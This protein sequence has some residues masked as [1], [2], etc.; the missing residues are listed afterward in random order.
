MKNIVVYI[1]IFFVVSNSIDS[2]LTAE[3]L[4]E[5]LKRSLAIGDGFEIS[6]KCNSETLETYWKS[7]S[8]GCAEFLTEPNFN[9]SSASQ[10]LCKQ[11]GKPLYE[12]VNDC[13]N[14]S[15]RYLHILDVICATNEKGETCYDALVIANDGVMFSDCE[16]SPCSEDCKGDLVASN[17]LHGCCMFS[18]VAVLSDIKRAELL[19]S[20]CDVESPDLC[21]GA[22]T[23]V[24][25]TRTQSSGAEFRTSSTVT[26]SMIICALYAV[27]YF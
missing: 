10:S 21:T 17:K 1:A 24:D 3:R 4:S 19:W 26:V 11:C 18:S 14:E 12:L 23:A 13:I 6:F 8:V 5:S 2:S 20:R 25:T 7:L 16:S 22:F 9:I 27:H 15:A